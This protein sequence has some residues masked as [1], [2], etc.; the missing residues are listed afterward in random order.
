MPGAGGLNRPTTLPGQVGGLNRPGMPGA[1]G[2]NRPTTLPGQIGGGNLGNRPPWGGGGG[3]LANRP[4]TLPGQIGNRPGGIGGIGNGGFN[5]GNRPGGVGGIGNGGFNPGNRPGGVG[6]IGNG[7]FNPGNRPGGIGGIGGLNRPG[8]GGGNNNNIGNNTNINVVNRP[9][10]GGNNFG[11]GNNWGGGNWGGNRPGGGWYGGGGNYGGGNWGGN[12]YGGGNWGGSRPGGGWYGGGGNTVVNNNYYGPGWSGANYGNWYH[13]GSGNAFWGGFAGALTGVGLSN[14]FRPGYGGY[15]YGYGSYGTAGYGYPYGYGVGGYNYG[16]MYSSMGYYPSAWSTPIYNSWGL[17]G[18]ANNWMYSGYSNPYLTPTTQTV[19]VQQPVPVVV[20]AGGVQQAPATQQVV[21]YDYSQP[22][23]V[24][25]APS[26]ASTAESAQKMFE[27]AR[28]RFK[29]GDY[30]QALS[31]ADQALTQ[32][33]NDPTLHE[34]RALTL[35]ALKRYDEA[36]A[37][38]YAVLSAGPSWNWATMVGL[39]PNVEAYTAQIRD[40][41]AFAK[42]NPTAAAP[43]FLLGYHYLVQDHKEASAARFAKVTELQPKDELSAKFAKLLAPAPAGAAPT[44]Q[45]TQVAQNNPPAGAAPAS[46]TAPAEGTQAPVEPPPAPPEAMAGTWVAKPD[47]KVTIT[48]T[49]GTDGAYTWSIAQGGQTQTITGKAGYQDDVL[50]LNQEEGPP[51][52]GKVKLDPAT[53]SFTF[54]PPGSAENVAGLS[55]SKQS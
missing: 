11:G 50:V 48:L 9:N 45:P 24:A 2:L 12:N 47:P 1:G 7:G 37:T 38:D 21:A 6:G 8:I 18:V 51:L 31:L 55:F 26:D 19:I 35:F 49:L 14:M 25:S 5:P 22:I 33:P 20:D 52:A 54:K 41:E 39:Y 29:A 42:A 53:N 3:N 27:T 40:L 13:G 16:G 43:Q 15:G 10:Y 17:G 28:D 23:D 32:L 30:G 44:Q 34:F 46:G 36:A 4:T